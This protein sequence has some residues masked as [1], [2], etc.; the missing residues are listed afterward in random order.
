RGRYLGYVGGTFA[1]ASIAGPP[2][3]GLF[4]D[5]LSWRWIFLANLPLGAVALGVVALVVPAQRERVRQQV[6]LLGVVLLSASLGPLTLALTLGGVEY[7]WASPTIV[8]LFSGGLAML[9]LFVLQERS[10]ADPLVP[11]ALFRNRIFTA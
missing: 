2:L 11:P 4:V 6:D 7:E 3:G 5:Q 8:A 10:A 9:V 1:I